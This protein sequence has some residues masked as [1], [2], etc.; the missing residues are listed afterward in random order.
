[1]GN[2]YKSFWLALVE[3]IDRDDPA[4]F[5]TRSG[6]AVSLGALQERAECLRES[7][8]SVGRWRFPMRCAVRAFHGSIP[9]CKMYFQVWP[10]N[11]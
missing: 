2:M 8:A 6:L 10:L 11:P 7:E 4:V 9:Q 3:A 1:M 5:C